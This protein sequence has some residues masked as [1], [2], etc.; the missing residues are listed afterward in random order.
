M[1][2]LTKGLGS[3]KPYEINEWEERSHFSPP[4]PSE[5]LGRQDNAFQEIPK[6]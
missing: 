2:E 3:K 6:P 1:R 4:E 5:E